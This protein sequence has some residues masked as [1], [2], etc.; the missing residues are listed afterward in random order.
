MSRKNQLSR[1]NHIALFQSCQKHSI[2]YL[3][4]AFDIESLRFINTKFNLR[5][6]K[7]ASGEIFSLDLLEY[8]SEINKPIILSTGM[9][10]YEEIEASIKI[11]NR[12]FRK[13]ITILHCISNYPTPYR[14]VNLN[15]MQ[16]LKN[17]FGYPVGFSDHTIGIEC[18][19][20]SVSMGA[21]IIEKHVTLDK[22][23]SGPD[24]KSS[25]TIDEF[26]Q[27]IIAVRNIEIALGKSDKEFSSDEIEIRNSAR[28]S[29][30]STRDI[31]KNKII[32]KKHICF[33][34]PGLGFSPLD[35]NLVIGR[36]AKKLI[37]K[38]RM[39][40]KDDID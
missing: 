30:I 24:H 15:V 25:V 21:S 8:I 27:L 7:I 40:R 33:K 10:T 17:R 5:Y 22:E 32:T 36:R 2:D 37:K 20:A 38:N 18:A 34:R 31:Q 23:Q 16:E 1:E 11:I 12:N 19:I 26:E 35:I 28:K 6:F 4:S 13:E 14:D 9:A 39:I 3:C 29:I